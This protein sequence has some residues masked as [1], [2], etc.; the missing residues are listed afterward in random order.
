MNCLVLDGAVC[1][2]VNAAYVEDVWLSSIS[3]YYSVSFSLSCCSELRQETLV[4]TQAAK[5]SSQF[6]EGE[7]KA[8]ELQKQVKKFKSEKR[9]V[10][11]VSCCQVELLVCVF[12]CVFCVIFDF[13][14][15]CTVSSAYCRM[16][17]TYSRASPCSPWDGTF[18]VHYICTYIHTC[19]LC[20]RMC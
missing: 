14:D 5:R 17:R 2:H 12:L 7:D 4:R 1:V 18:L 19:G 16:P 3:A 8:A 10:E 11:D 6:E 13:E 20:I 15:M 9:A